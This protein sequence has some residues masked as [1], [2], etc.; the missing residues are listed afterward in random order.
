MIR[1]FLSCAALTLASL[2]CASAMSRGQDAAPAVA[3]DVTPPPAPEPSVISTATSQDFS[4]VTC[5]SSDALA[6]ADAL[7]LAAETHDQL[8]TLLKLGLGWRFP[9]HIRIMAP[10]DPLL[11]KVDHAA[12]GVFAQGDTMK[13]EAVVPSTDPNL[14]EF[15]QRQY[16]TALLWEKFFAK[17]TTFDKST[18]ISVVPFWLIEGLRGWL[19]P[20][21]DHSRESIVRRAVHSQTVPTLEEVTN[22]HE[23]SDDRLL[24]LW[25]KAFSFYLVDSITQSGPRRADF[26]QWL[27]GLAAPDASPLAQFHFPQETAWQRELTE[28]ATR[29]H[30]IVYTWDE[31]LAQL[32]AAQT[33]TFAPSKDAKVET[34][35][36]FEVPSKPHTTMMFEA[37]QERI[38]LLT[39]LEL[40]A[41]ASWNPIIEMERSALTLLIK[42][43][44]VDNA[45]KLLTAAQKRIADETAQHQRLADYVNWFEVTKNFE[46]NTTHFATY[47]A[48]A[49][50]ME[51]VEA[52][53]EH[54]N[55]IRANLLQI[56][57]EL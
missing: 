3:P 15:I 47:Y 10:D 52:D 45:Q 57:S 12:S 49:K 26:Q 17:T 39:E 1:R 46:G 19:N 7:Q 44:Q 51:R 9:V 14:R 38:Y 56:E 4:Q 42:D 8:S 28:S 32:T 29:S 37:I 24:G 48:T 11:A 2:C 25:Q 6:C 41:H 21:P 27:D 22:W 18:K 35:S 50:E 36:I 13:L 54:P 34:C 55:P 40:R 23:L 33:V 16:V 30:D 53:P 31:T 20:D 5:T 43:N